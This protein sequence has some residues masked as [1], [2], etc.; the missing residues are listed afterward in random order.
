[1]GGDLLVD[2]LAAVPPD[3]D[4]VG[5]DAL[6]HNGAIAGHLDNVDSLDIGRVGSRPEGK[7]LV[8][9]GSGLADDRLELLAGGELAQRWIGRLPVERT[10]VMTL[11]G[12]RLPIRPAGRG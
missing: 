11:S 10:V 8:E 2:D 7:A 12:S 4:P 6:L 1:V 5:D 3:D 9:I